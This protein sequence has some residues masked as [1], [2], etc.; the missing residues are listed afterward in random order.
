MKGE[1][2]M[3]RRASLLIILLL[4]A[5]MCIPVLSADKQGTEKNPFKGKG[6]IKQWVSNGTVAPGSSSLIAGDIAF[7][8]KGGFPQ[9]ELLNPG[10][11][12]GG[13]IPMAIPSY[14]QAKLFYFL[15]GGAESFFGKNESLVI[16]LTGK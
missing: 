8:L 3:M 4:C 11:K 7:C 15:H 9:N 16:N 2:E 5:V 6:P 12:T 1:F 14:A 13:V 10:A